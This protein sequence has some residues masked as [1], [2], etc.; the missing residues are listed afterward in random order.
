MKF[1]AR[2]EVRIKKE[3]SD[4]ESDTIRKSLLDLNFQLGLLRVAKVYEIYLEA[5][6]KKEAET[7]ARLMCSRLLVNPTKDEFK[8]EVEPVGNIS[9][10]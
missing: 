10:S 7:M 4:P 9:K 2:I 3:Q 1:R 8:L 5:A 6:S